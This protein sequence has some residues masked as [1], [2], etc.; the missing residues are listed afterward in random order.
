M[1]NFNFFRFYWKKFK[2][3]WKKFENL[4]Y[5]FSPELLRCERALLKTSGISNSLLNNS[6]INV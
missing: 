1:K 2:E 5:F 6:L 3:K 4:I